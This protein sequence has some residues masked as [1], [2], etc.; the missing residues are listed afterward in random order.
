MSF[1][2]QPLRAAAL[3]L[4]AVPAMA[5]GQIRTVDPSSPEVAASARGG[6]MAAGDADP[7]DEPAEAPV[8]A[9]PRRAVT[10]VP[11]AAGTA[12][13]G[14]AR[15]GLPTDSTYK[16]EEIFGAAERVFGKGAQGLAKLVED[17]LR[18]QGRPTAYIAGREAG[19]AIAIGLRYGQGDLFHKVEGSQPIYWTGPSLGFDI[20]GN[21]SKTFIL[22]YNLYDGEDMFRRF[23]LVEGN[24][25][26]VGGF[27]ASYLKRGDVVLIP[28]RLGVGWRFG[29]S[30][31]YMRFSKKGRVL[32]F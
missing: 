23:P 26:A 6:E 12:A 29:A 17:V 21:G 14:E 25:Y 28:I 15:T 5:A 7:A 2:F 20:G 22:V 31:G 32:P 19:G 24:L 8:R 1:Q 3:L 16:D 30:V 10:P 13:A 4:L 11:D 27:T 18:K 9:A